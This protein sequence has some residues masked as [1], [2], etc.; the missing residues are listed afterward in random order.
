MKKDV[1]ENNRYRREIKKIQYMYNGNLLRRKP[2][3]W[4]RTNAKNDKSGKLK[5]ES[6]YI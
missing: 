1:R 4:N 2:M 3:Q 6:V 5:T